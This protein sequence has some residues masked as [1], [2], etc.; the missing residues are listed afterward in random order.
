MHAFPFQDFHA[1]YYHPSNARFW[2][3]GND[4]PEERL[5]MLAEYLDQFEARPVD[6]HVEKQP[7][8]PEPRRVVDRYAA[9]DNE[10]AEEDAGKVRGH[11]DQPI[12][13]AAPRPSYAC[14]DI[15]PRWL[16]HKSF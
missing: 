4:P 2:F 14:A 1:Q 5:R 6:S 9:S 12:V 10:G 15:T 8:F 3:Y 13:A 16:V 7:L 11:S